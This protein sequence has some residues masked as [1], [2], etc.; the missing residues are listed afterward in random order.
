M[1][2]R[3][4]PLARTAV[5]SAIGDIAWLP[6]LLIWF[7]S[8][9]TMTFVLVYTGFSRRPEHGLGVR[10]V[11]ETCVGGAH[12]WRFACPRRLEVTCRVAAEHHHRLRNGIGFAGA[13]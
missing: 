13:H 6:I 2:A 11:P 8:A 10:S 5:L 3:V 1:P 7:V 9:Y 4:N 12:A